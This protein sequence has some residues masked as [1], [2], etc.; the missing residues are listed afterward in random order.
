MSDSSS[1][2][3]H[4]PQPVIDAIHV[5]ASHCRD[6][7]LVGAYVAQTGGASFYGECPVKERGE[8]L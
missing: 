2:P 8:L 1:P 4:T 5:I 3:P 6:A 7:G